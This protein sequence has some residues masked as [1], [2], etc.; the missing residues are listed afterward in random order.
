MAVLHERLSLT[1]A[2]DLIQSVR[3][4][5]G[6]SS[7]SVRLPPPPRA[8]VE[9]YQY[10][11]ARAASLAAPPEA[12]VQVGIENLI[13]PMRNWL[14]E[15]VPRASRSRFG[16]A[17]HDTSLALEL[18]LASSELES[19]PWELIGDVGVLGPPDRRVTVWRS[20]IAPVDP[21]ASKPWTNILLLVSSAAMLRVG[22][23]APEEIRMIAETIGSEESVRV[24]SHEGV[25]ADFGKL[26]RDLRPS[27]F[28]LVAHATSDF[29]RF[30]AERGPTLAE[31]QVDPT[32]LA[33]EIS[34]SPVRLVMLNCCNSASP[35]SNGQRPAAYEVACQS[36]AAT[37]GMSGQLQPFV[38]ARFASA[39]YLEAARG[40][41]VLASFEAGQSAIRTNPT[42][43]S[44]WSIPTMYSQSAD[45]IPFPVTDAARIRLGLQEARAHL[46]KLDADLAELA[47]KP[48]LTPGDWVSWSA[49]VDVR[50]ECIRDYVL[51]MP[52]GGGV[53]MERRGGA[54][55]IARTGSSVL[56]F[57]TSVSHTVGVL[58]D[59]SE[60][61]K[62]R[63]LAI[64]RLIIH[65]QQNRRVLSGL[66]QALEAVG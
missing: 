43:S 33:A 19:Y 38:G 27:G 62:S 15:A 42:Y 29:F 32:L 5:P 24:L 30:Q 37:V 66:A 18:T 16:A 9:D 55:I 25:T 1:F 12:G 51:S 2:D 47:A 50:V 52:S 59:P 28:H 21:T 3:L 34:R 41:S 64:E 17:T 8:V 6:Q 10:A 63:R 26:L 48:D 39:F 61:S 49:R 45:V 4:T 14:A 23:Y 35:G 57:L 20:V 36:G 54:R 65:R 60:K 31:L 46:E 13:M 53:A 7:E 58:K 11:L 22:P 40:G 44:M 56:S